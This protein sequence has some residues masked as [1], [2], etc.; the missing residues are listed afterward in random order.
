MIEERNLQ[1]IELE[2]QR[3][4]NSFSKI[5]LLGHYYLGMMRGSEGRS[6]CNTTP[7]EKRAGNGSTRISIGPIKIIWR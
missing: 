3:R 1:R 6:T 2:V 7:R 5:I 4:D